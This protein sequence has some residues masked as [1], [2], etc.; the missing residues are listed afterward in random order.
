MD[1]EEEQAAA[2]QTAER[3]LA[4]RVLTNYTRMP[5]KH[6]EDNLFYAKEGDGYGRHFKLIWKYR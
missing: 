6:I 5:I 1:T 2:R 4:Y 3:K